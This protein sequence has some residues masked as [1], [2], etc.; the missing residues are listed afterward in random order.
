[1]QGLP[2]WPQT[3]SAYASEINFLFVSLLVISILTAGL[4]IFLLLFFANKYRQ[5]SKADRS[6]TIKKTWRWEVGWTTA[7]LLVFVGLAI[8]GGDIYLRLYNPP[9][10]AL[11]IFIVGKQWMW[12]AQHPGG[13]R[14]INELHVPAGQDVRLVL[15]SED[16]IHSFY[17]PA[18]RIKQDVVPGRYETM[19][20]RADQ[21]G[22]Y[23]IF[24]SEYCGTDHAHM[25]GWLTVLNP[26]EYA[27]WLRDQ[28]GEGT[29][30]AQG[31][32]LFHQY[33]CSGCHEPG[34]TVRAPPLEG[35]YGSPVPLSD[36]S[37]VVAND[38]YIRDSILDPKAQVAAGYQPVMPTFAGQMSEDDLAKLV[39]YI[40]SIG[41]NRQPGAA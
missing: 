19:W 18:L 9:P 11:Q 1:V 15:A 13:Q 38:K 31:A 14:E 5:G 12:K 30:A 17:V 16:V 34:G 39:A 24:C 21:P 20:F 32:R 7:S 33:G 29:L 3:A 36:G 25:G 10:N 2:L 8:W 35:L 4:V 23:H 28:G 26:R 37:V 22:R 40:Q 41:R 6:G 27:L